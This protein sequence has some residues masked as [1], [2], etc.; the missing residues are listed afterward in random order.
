MTSALCTPEYADSIVKRLWEKD[1]NE[2]VVIA[3]ESFICPICRIGHT[4]TIHNGE[5]LY[6]SHC[7]VTVSIYRDDLERA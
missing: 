7:G 4:T 3:R 6:C 5:D 1:W 2:P